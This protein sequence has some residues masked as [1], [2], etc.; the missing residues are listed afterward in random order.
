MFVI[1]LSWW[2][3]MRL[4]SSHFHCQ[5]FDFFLSSCSI[6]Q[7]TCF[8][9]S[10]TKSSIEQEEIERKTR[11]SIETFLKDRQ[12]MKIFLV[13]AEKSLL[14]CFQLTLTLHFFDFQIIFNQFKSQN[15]HKTLM[16]T[17]K[18]IFRPQTSLS[19]FLVHV[20]LRYKEK[21]H[22]KS[23]LLAHNILMRMSSELWRWRPCACGIL[24]A[25]SDIHDVYYRNNI[26][27][28]EKNEFSRM[29][30]WVNR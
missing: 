22:K 13:V 5:A 26:S 11:K 21:A 20:S 27:R 10:F 3:Q 16:K 17:F 2:M 7:K 6:F 9:F 25:Y 28:K 8:S 29:R 14:L 15:S 12:K 24:N 18:N 30:H 23:H 19:C 1:Y 4:N